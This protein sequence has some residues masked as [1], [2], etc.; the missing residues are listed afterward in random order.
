MSTNRVEQRQGASWFCRSQVRRCVMVLNSECEQ[1]FVGFPEGTKRGPPVGTEG[2]GRCIGERACRS[3]SSRGSGMVCWTCVPRR[4]VD[5]K[6]CGRGVGSRACVPCGR[7]ARFSSEESGWRRK[8]ENKCRPLEKSKRPK[9]ASLLSLVCRCRILYVC[10]GGSCFHRSKGFVVPGQVRL[11]CPY[12][13]LLFCR[14]AMP[15]WLWCY[16]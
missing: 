7:K 16:S 14:R 2:G 5:S 10:F 1:C 12:E 13:Q 11:L 6:S 15:R 3:V 9:A 8:D 4:R